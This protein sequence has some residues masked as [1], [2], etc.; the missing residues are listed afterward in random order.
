MERLK[1]GFNNFFGLEPSIRA[2]F[3]RCLCAIMLII[4][5]IDLFI[6]L[7]KEELGK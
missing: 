3:F 5:F 4:L 1:D 2:D 7:S 6:Q